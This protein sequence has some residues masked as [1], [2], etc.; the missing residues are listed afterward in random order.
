MPSF[1]ETNFPPSINLASEA[2]TLVLEAASALP[3][4]FFLNFFFYIG[5]LLINNAVTVAGRHSGG[6]YTYPFSS[7]SP[8]I[9]A[10]SRVPCATQQVLAGPA[11]LN[12]AAVR[13]IPS[14]LGFVCMFFISHCWYL[15]LQR[16]LF[17]YFICFCNLGWRALIF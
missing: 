4:F 2:R 7:N 8:P 1:I 6:T 13:Q 16:L 17:I 3:V 12:T 10:W 14:P 9:Q 11:F 15:V 5:V